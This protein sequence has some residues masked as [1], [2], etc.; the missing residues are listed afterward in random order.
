MRLARHRV[1]PFWLRAP[2]GRSG[3]EYT[4]AIQFVEWPPPDLGNRA[5]LQPGFP[6]RRGHDMRTVALAWKN[7]PKP[8]IA[9]MN[10]LAGLNS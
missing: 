8:E 6:G 1:V 10:L 3:Q 7:I 2:S 9:N 5:R 4:F